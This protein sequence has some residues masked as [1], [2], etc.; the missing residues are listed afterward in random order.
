MANRR[1]HSPVLSAALVLLA[2]GACASAETHEPEAVAA[3][4]TEVPEP[5]PPP[6]V[7]A[8]PARP[9]TVCPVEHIGPPKLDPWRFINYPARVI[10]VRRGPAPGRGKGDL[11][12]LELSLIAAGDEVLLKLANIGK[13]RVWW[14]GPDTHLGRL[15]AVDAE[16]EVIARPKQCPWL[17]PP[18]PVHHVSRW[19]K[20]TWSLVPGESALLVRGHAR[21]TETG[22]ILELH[23]TSPEP[24]FEG[25][26]LVI[27]GD[28][29]RLQ[30]EWG[31]AFAREGWCHLR[32][33]ENWDSP[34][35]AI[36]DR[37]WTSLSKP[38]WVFPADREAI[39]DMP[40]RGEL[41]SNQVEVVSREFF[42]T[43]KQ[44]HNEPQAPDPPATD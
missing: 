6:P 30:G 5:E 39:D 33:K 26:C 35:S 4:D 24:V 1:T 36:K 10:P 38:Q 32:A 18:E 31:L 8:P 14:C 3:A 43:N 34:V 40:D 11:A 27:E 41:T 16:G 9:P 20:G 22:L 25:K 2:F 29:A 7:E 42:A 15:Y 12:G 37:P 28:R 19:R 23:D 21:Q 44:I 17:P 13:R